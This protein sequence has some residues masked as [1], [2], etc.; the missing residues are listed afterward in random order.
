[1]KPYTNCMKQIIQTQKV[2]EGIVYNYTLYREPKRELINYRWVTKV[3]FKLVIQWKDNKRTLLHREAL[4]LTM[5][6]LDPQNYKKGV[7]DI[8]GKYNDEELRKLFNEWLENE[9]NIIEPKLNFE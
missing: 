4:I 6:D 8:C 1:M 5:W 7:S 2:I 9:I 3:N